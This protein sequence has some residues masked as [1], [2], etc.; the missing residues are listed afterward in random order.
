[1]PDHDMPARILIVVWPEASAYN[2][3]FQL[4]RILQRRG[5]RV[6]YATPQRWELY[7]SRQGFETVFLDASVPLLTRPM[8]QGCSS[9]VRQEARERLKELQRSMISIGSFDL[10]L[11]HPT[12]WH[13]ALV[14][15]RLGVP[16][17]SANANMGS[18]WNLRVPPVFSRLQPSPRRLANSVRC[19]AAWLAMRYFGAFAHRHW[20]IIQA[21]PDNIGD[22][23]HDVG[24]AARH[25]VHSIFEPLYMPV[26]YRILRAARRE[27]VLIR[28]GDYGHRLLGTELVFGPRAIDF[29][30]DHHPGRRVYAGIS[31]DMARVEDSFDWSLADSR[32]PL[33][34]CAIGSHGA[35]W[36]AG[37]RL[38]LLKAVVQSFRTHP[39]RRLLLQ[40]AGEEERARLAPLP[41]N[42]VA[43]TWYPQLAVLERTSVF[44]SHG[45]LGSVREALFFGVPMIIFPFGVDQP[46][47]AARVTRA[48]VGLSGDIRTVTADTISSMLWAVE[49]Q[50]FR[51][52]ALRLSKVVRVHSECED[53]VAAVERACVGHASG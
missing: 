18:T 13:Y 17:L 4:S 38:R 48:R 37:N 42:V 23:V 26:Y 20:G 32:K 40:I 28:W 7:V 52:N 16:Y 50:P 43:A 6:V 10:V 53:A 21:M 9:V 1:M 49:R 12:L 30:Q 36:N 22:S 14:L 25:F 2:A 29:C 31:V 51:E 15:R 46:G 19:G 44:I 35:Y 45:G 24:I 41:G 8:E 39:E 34:Y 3:T 5:H 27:G 47:N 11:L 33:V